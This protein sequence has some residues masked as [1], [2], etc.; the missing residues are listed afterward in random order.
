YFF[1]EYFEIK[2]AFPENLNT[3][4]IKNIVAGYIKT[5]N[6]NDNKTLW[7]S[8]IKTLAENLGFA[9]RTKDYKKN[10]EEFNGNI[11]DIV[12]VIRVKE[13]GRKNSPDLYEIEQVLGEDKVL[14]RLK[15]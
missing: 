1:D 2:A 13:T 15:N 4:T 3:D 5:R 10:P 8:K 14:G 6:F 11:S 7:F 9:T 12:T